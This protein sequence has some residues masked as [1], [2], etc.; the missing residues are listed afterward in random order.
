MVGSDRANL[1]QTGTTGG[2]CLTDV[3]KSDLKAATLV[4]AA[5][6][7]L[8]LNHSMRYYFKIPFHRRLFSL[9]RKVKS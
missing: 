7:L 3:V 2:E 4:P 1:K 5:E 6:K 8:T 9:I